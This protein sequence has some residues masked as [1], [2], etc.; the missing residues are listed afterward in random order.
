MIYRVVGE[1]TNNRRY[2]HNTGSYN[3]QAALAPGLRRI[4]EF[5]SAAKKVE[6]LRFTSKTRGC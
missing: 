3:S 4:I 6:S 1:N 2:T 5:V